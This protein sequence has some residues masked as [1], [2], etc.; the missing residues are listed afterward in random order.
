ML[1][2]FLYQNASDFESIL[3]NIQ[4]AHI[5]LEIEPPTIIISTLTLM[6]ILKKKN[7]LHYHANEI[8]HF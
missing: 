6:C 1:P 3:I 7:K 2:D 4:L 8:G 5:S